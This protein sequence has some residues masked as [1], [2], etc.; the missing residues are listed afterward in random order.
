MITQ[1]YVQHHPDDSGHPG[2]AVIHCNK[3]PSAG[4]LMEEL[5]GQ[6]FEGNVVDI[7]Y[8]E[9]KLYDRHNHLTKEGVMNENTFIVM[10]WP[11]KVSYDFKERQWTEEWMQKLMAPKDQAFPK[12]IKFELM[13][14]DVF[15]M[16]AAKICYK[17]KAA[18]SRVFH[19]LDGRRVLNRTLRTT[20]RGIQDKELRRGFS[21]RKRLLRKEANDS[22]EVENV[23]GSLCGRNK[24]K[25]LQ[26]NLKQLSKLRKMRGGR[27][28]RQLMHQALYI[29]I[30]K[31]KMM[32]LRPQKRKRARKPRDPNDKRPWH[33]KRK[34]KK[35]GKD[36]I[37][38]KNVKTL[39]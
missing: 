33:V 29:N 37:G 20:V 26:L 22:K 32:I 18:A 39:S 31:K 8:L 6:R 19:A 24:V 2:Y 35:E 12:P 34:E 25:T 27:Y 36:K 13:A 4:W 23:N 16:G 38:V 5:N 10:H 3:P 15:P 1:I 28:K 11:M 9:Q 7:E 14:Y 21:L 17:D 30:K